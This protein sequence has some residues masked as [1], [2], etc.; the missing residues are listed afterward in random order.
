MC[1]NPA[2]LPSDMQKVRAVNAPR[3]SNLTDVIVFSGKGSQSKVSVLSGGE[4]D[5]N[6]V[7]YNSA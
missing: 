3:S 1:A 4:Y 2:L 7:F 5:G 6:T